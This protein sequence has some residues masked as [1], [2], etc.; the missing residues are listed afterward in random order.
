[1]TETPMPIPNPQVPRTIVDKVIRFCL[2]QKLVV[3]LIVLFVVAWGIFVA[4]FDWNVPGVKRRPVPTDAIPDIGENQQIVYSEWMGRSP[5]D[6]DDQVSYPLT[7]SLLGVPGVKTIR[8]TSM[9]GFSV[10]LVIFDEDVSFEASQNRVIARLNGLPSGILPEGVK[11]ALGPYATALGQIFWYTL[12]G[13]DP[14]NRPIGGWDLNEL[15]TWQD[16]FVRY[17]LQAAEGITEVA[18]VG[19][20]VQEYQIDVDPD[21]MRAFEVT[22]PEVFNAVRMSNIDVGA[23]QIEVNRVEYLIRAR[24]FIR[25]L[26]DIENTVIAERENVPVYVKN[27]AKVSLGPSLREGALDKAG[28]EA[29]GAIVVARSGY[30]PLEAIGN[31]KKKIDEIRPSMPVKVVADYTKTTAGALDAFARAQGFEPREGAELNQKEWVAW[32]QKT[33]RPEWPAAVTTS[34]LTVV[35]YY[36]RTK[37]IYETLGTLNDALYEQ[38]LITSIVTIVM[39]ANLPVGFL[40]SAVMPLAVGFS[41]IAMKLIGVEANIVSLSGIAIAIGTIVDMG[42]ILCQNILQHL[43]DAPPDEPRIEVIYRASSEVGSAVVTAISTTVVGFLPVFAMTGPEGRLFRPLAFT[44][45]FC[46]IGSVIAALTVIPA[47]AHILLAGRIESKTLKRVLSAGLVVAALLLGLRLGWWLL[48]GILAAVGVWFFVKD[49]LPKIVQ[50]IVKWSANAV[51]V[52]IIGILL[53]AHWMPLGIGEG[54][55]RNF[56]IVAILIGTFQIFYYIVQVTYG[57]VLRF[58]LRFKLLFLA[59]PVVITLVGYIG[60]LGFAAMFHWLPGAPPPVDQTAQTTEAQPPKAQAAKYWVYL[61]HRFPGFGNEFMPPLD[62]GSYLYMPTTMPHASIGEALDVISKQDMAIRGIPEVDSVVGKI[63]RAMTALDPAPV[64]MIETVVNYKSEYVSDKDGRPILYRY[65]RTKGPKGTFARDPNGDLI[66][67]ENGRPFR[68]WRDHI[69]GPD[70]IWH[71]VVN[72]AKMPGTT[73]APKLQP[74]AARII[75]LQSGMRAPMGVKVYGPSLESIEGVGIQIER[76]LKDVAMVEPASVVAD[77]IVGKPYLEIDLDREALARY[78]MRVADVQE[79][80][81]VAIGGVQ[82]TTTVEGLKR[83]PVRVRYSRE[84]RDSLET[85]DKILISSMDGTQVPLSQV[86]K[87]EYV[88]GPESIKR[89]GPLLVSYVLF[90]KKPDY[91]EVD[92]VQACQNYLRTKKDETKE[93]VLPPGVSYKFAGN[94]ENQLHATDT[95]RWV[96][97]LT[98]FVIFIIIYFQFRS[99]ITTTLIFSTI[100][101]CWGGGLLYIWL[102]GQPWFLDFTL[103]G[104]DFRNLF[105]VHTINMSVAI[106]VG[107]LALFG[108]ASDDAVVICTYLEQRFTQVRPGSIPDIREATVYAGKRRIKACLMTTA[109]TVLALLP[110]LTS[111]G[112]GSDIMVPMS[113]PS[114]GGMIIEVITMFMAPV[115]YCLMMEWRWRAGLKDKRLTPKAKEA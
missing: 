105:H 9:F 95:L 4:P 83:F 89:E 94:Y 37:L 93:L 103:F 30:N 47:A 54:F 18:P 46:L 79:A 42:I 68:Q 8:S 50:T 86:S 78:G 59:M 115:L 31:V 19:G 43:E 71:E 112:R 12:E 65:D 73:T 98:L 5:K 74:I 45:T 81:E 34:T 7:V 77:R 61:N 26:K 63:G 62:E 113:L 16:F 87:V 60:W 102:Y 56:I 91:A 76:F 40:I 32:L 111:T 90:D 82:L 67:D 58:F 96:I 27:V 17:H 13:R 51:A 100:F 72:A 114:F 1:M 29:V 108:I 33:P 21:A 106:W 88:R 23:K 38:I 3:A 35:P 28:A 2:E 101:V 53:T 25:G 66:P 6:V 11:P 22:L 85:L 24:G 64:N 107:F 97:P 109:T 75:M 49:S 52:I 41:F 99:V 55:S 10:I 36:D 84:L 39:A 14:D 15:R 44:K 92:V 57:P 20:F 104:V 70:D 48:A 69:K 110:V 80:I